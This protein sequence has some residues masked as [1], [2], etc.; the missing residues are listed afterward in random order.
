M[1]WTLICGSHLC[2]FQTSLHWPHLTSLTSFLK[3]FLAH[4]ESLTIFGKKNTLLYQSV[5]L[6]NTQNSSQHENCFVILPTIYW[7]MKKQSNI[8][9]PT[10]LNIHLHANRPT[11]I[12]HQTS[13]AH[14]KALAEQWCE[15]ISI[16]QI[17]DCRTRILLSRIQMQW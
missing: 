13:K 15:V 11:T 1:N 2:H 6:S 7:V 9:L 4:L 17:Q 3:T 10:A 14:I 12:V 5:C 16:T 8:C